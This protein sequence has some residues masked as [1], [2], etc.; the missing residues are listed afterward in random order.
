MVS[1]FAQHEGRADGERRRDEALALVAARRPVPRWRAQ[2]NLLEAMRSRPDR[3]G[4]GDDCTEV[5]Y[6]YADNGSHVGAAVRELAVRGII[7]RVGH[8]RS[9][10]PSR[11]GNE[12]KVWTLTDDAAADAAIA[13]LRTILAALQPNDST[14]GVTGEESTLFY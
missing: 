5:G 14:P 8:V 1:T 13:H 7:R 4:S 11:K 10:R 3:C 12:T 9:S 6:E 2:L